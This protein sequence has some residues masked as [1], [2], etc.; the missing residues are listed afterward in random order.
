MPGLSPDQV[1]KIHELLHKKQLIQAV[2]LYHQATGVS[3]A[4]AKEAVEEMALV[5]VSKPPSG[6]RSY[7]DPVMESKIRSLLAKGKKIEAVKIYREEYG[8]GLKEA[9]DA[10]DRIEASM[11][12][13]SATALPY[14]S[15]IGRNPF[16]ENEGGNRGKVIVLTAVALVVLCAAAVFLLILMS[17]P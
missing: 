7:D 12:R 13:D 11:P 3:L 8:I 6:V 16:E 9:K 17:N 2:Q 10:V 14:E 15:A 5:E 1:Q 4:E